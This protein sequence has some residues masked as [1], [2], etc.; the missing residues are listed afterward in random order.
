M[1]TA[2]V[3]VAN[4]DVRQGHVI[5]A[6]GTGAVCGLEVRLEDVEGLLRVREPETLGRLNEVGD[7]AHSDAPADADGVIDEALSEIVN[8]PELRLA[9][10]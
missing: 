4:E 3:R 9:V 6:D 2:R 1:Q 5:G 10:G 7:L 8:A